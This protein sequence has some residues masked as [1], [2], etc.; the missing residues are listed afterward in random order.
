MLSQRCS[1]ARVAS[2][3][4]MLDPFCGSSS[5]FVEMNTPMAMASNLRPRSGSAGE[6]G[7]AAAHQRLDAL[8]ELL[9]TD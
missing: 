5:T 2:P 8:T 4:L 7:V 3:Y 1:G 9:H 6:P